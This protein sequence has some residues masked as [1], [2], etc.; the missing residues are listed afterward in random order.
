[1]R[2]IASARRGSRKPCKKPLSSAA[3][4]GVRYPP[5]R[6]CADVPPFGS[7]TS[8]S[9]CQPSPNFFCKPH[10]R[11]W[12]LVGDAS[13]DQGPDH[14]PGMSD[15]FQ[16][17]STAL[18]PSTRPWV[19]TARS[20]RRWATTNGRVERCAADVRVHHPDRHV[21]SH[22]RRTCS[23]YWA[24]STAIRTRWNSSSVSQ[25]EQRPRPSSSPGSQSGGYGRCRSDMTRRLLL[26]P[27]GPVA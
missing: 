16:D 17:A 4:E 7:L 12:T 22:R 27:E 5:S 26:G 11:G 6:S 8:A 19:G 25:P 10:G 15:A 23:N 3:E 9:R 1:M 24:Q 18:S 20:T 2:K 13:L 14:R 21:G